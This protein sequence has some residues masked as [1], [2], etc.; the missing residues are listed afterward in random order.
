M[1]RLPYYLYVRSPTR[2]EKVDFLW[3]VELNYGIVGLERRGR[4]TINKRFSS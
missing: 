3:D 2:F 1:Q 4:G